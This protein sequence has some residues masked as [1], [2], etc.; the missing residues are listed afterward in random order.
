MFLYIIFPL[1]SDS[2]NLPSSINFL[3]SWISS[4]YIVSLPNPHILNPLYSF[5]LW[6]AVIIIDGFI[7][8][9]SL[10][11]YVVGVAQSPIF[12][13]STPI[14]VIP[15]AKAA[16][17]SS[18]DNLISWPTIILFCPALFIKVAKPFPIFSAA[19]AF[20]SVG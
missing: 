11:K 18:P 15:S 17:K 7:P 1:V 9:S 5:G 12:I 16:N 20:I 6:L 2:S 4:P 19:S 10:A 3:K 14:D 8:S 13:T